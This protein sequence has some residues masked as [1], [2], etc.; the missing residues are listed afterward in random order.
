MSNVEGQM[1]N[2]RCGHVV[3]FKRF[4]DRTSVES[5]ERTKEIHDHHQYRIFG[6]SFELGPAEYESSSRFVCSCVNT[7]LNKTSNGCINATLRRVRITIVAVEK[8]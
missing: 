8:Q 7:S 6:K 1:L 3:V 5:L 2:E 4:R